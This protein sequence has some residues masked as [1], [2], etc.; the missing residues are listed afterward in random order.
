MTISYDAAADV[1]YIMF[2]DSGRIECEYAE[3]QEGLILRLD[4]QSGR[5]FGCTI[6]SF[7]RRLAREPAI[8]IPE[9]GAVPSPV[10]A[11]LV[12]ASID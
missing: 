4:P 1:L 7:M 8:T 5:I 10:P 3:R 12:R 11:G 2:A 6:G 9:I